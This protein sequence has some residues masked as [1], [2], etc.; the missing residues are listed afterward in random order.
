M[1]RFIQEVINQNYFN[2]YDNVKRV[3]YWLPD[4]ICKEVTGIGHTK[5]KFYRDDEDIIYEHKRCLGSNGINIAMIESD[6][7]NRSLFVELE[8]IDEEKRKKETCRK[9]LKRSDLKFMVTF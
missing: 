1:E 6:A 5:R 7:P 2:Y 4:E 8:E 3:P 9:S